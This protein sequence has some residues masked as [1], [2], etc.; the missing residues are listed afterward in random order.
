MTIKKLIIEAKKHCRKYENE[1]DA[2]GEKKTKVKNSTW[3]KAQ[4]L[5]STISEEPVIS[6]CS[7]GSID[8]IWHKELTTLVN[9]GI[10]GEIEIGSIKNKAW[11]NNS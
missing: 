7:N 1:P 10:N 4:E 6:T 8:I 2:E 11:K 9:I 3:L 5:L